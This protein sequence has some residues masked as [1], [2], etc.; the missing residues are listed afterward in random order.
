V[1]SGE[2]AKAK[3]FLQGRYKLYQKDFNQDSGPIFEAPLD[4]NANAL[5]LA[6][7]QGGN[8]GTIEIIPQSNTATGSLN[9]AG[10]KKYTGFGKILDFTFQGQ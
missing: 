2:I 3:L 10:T 5:V 7:N 1:A 6:V 4:L 9:I 8:N